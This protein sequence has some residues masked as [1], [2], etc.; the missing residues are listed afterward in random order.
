MRRAGCSAAD[1]G[2][3]CFGWNTGVSVDQFIA[4]RLSDA[5]P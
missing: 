4:G 1:Q 2:G 3:R 5:L